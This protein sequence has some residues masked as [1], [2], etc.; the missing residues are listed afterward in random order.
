MCKTCDTLLSWTRCAFNLPTEKLNSN[1]TN[2]LS[3]YLFNYCHPDNFC[4]DEKYTFGR[5]I[6]K[7]ANTY[8][9]EDSDPVLQSLIKSKLDLWYVERTKK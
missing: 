8:F 1:L 4:N 9:I 2:T 3:I 5:Y 7:L 6:L